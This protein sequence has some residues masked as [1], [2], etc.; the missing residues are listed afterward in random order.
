MFLPKTA[1]C[2]AM[3]KGGVALASKDVEAIMQLLIDAEMKM[4]AGLDDAGHLHAERRHRPAARPAVERRVP[5]LP[6]PRARERYGAEPGFITMNVPRLLDVLDGLGIENPIVCANINKIGFRMCG[7]VDALRED[8]REHA[9]SGR[10]RCRCSPRARSRRA[11]RS[12]TSVGSRR[13]ESIVFG[14]SSRANIRQTKAL[15][16]E[17]WQAP[18]EQSPPKLKSPSVIGTVAR[19]GRWLSRGSHS[20]H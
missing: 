9:A 10:S 19:S 20:P 13:I 5:D 17:L 2:Q 16:D 15:I 6:R 8:D 14:A 12:S 7:G 3:L 11:R 1:P 18:R 4:F